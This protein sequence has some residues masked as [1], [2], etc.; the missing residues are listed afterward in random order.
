M[1]MGGA[2]A[3]IAWI[4]LTPWSKLK[5]LKQLEAGEEDA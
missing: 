4:A 3:S 1:I 5:R 2:I